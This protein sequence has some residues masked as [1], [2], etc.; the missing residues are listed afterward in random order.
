MLDGRGMVVE[1]EIAFGGVGGRRAPVDH[2]VVPG[3]VPV[4]LGLVVQV[5]GV[6]G[7]AL[8]VV[9]DDDAPVPIAPVADDL[10]DFESGHRQPARGF[11]RES[12]HAGQPT[13]V[14]GTRQAKRPLPFR[15]G[16]V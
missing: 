14:S 4:G 13:N 9:I 10:P 7:L 15:G 5:P 16:S 3:L 2:H 6:V 8:Q 12:D 1:P 11:F